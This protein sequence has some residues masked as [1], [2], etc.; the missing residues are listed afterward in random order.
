MIMMKLCSLVWK[1]KSL[2]RL[3]GWHEVLILTYKL[4]I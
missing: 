3:I 1:N 4:D 2:F